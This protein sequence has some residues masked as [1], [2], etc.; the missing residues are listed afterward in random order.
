MKTPHWYLENALTGS[1]FGFFD[2]RYDA[3]RHA[4]AALISFGVFLTVKSITT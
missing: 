4:W 3:E 1:T 2:T